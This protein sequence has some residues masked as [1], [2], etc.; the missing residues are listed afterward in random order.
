MGAGLEFNQYRAYNIGDDLR[1]LD[2]KLLARSDKYYLKQ[3]SI[4]RQNKVRFLLDTSASMQY[5]EDGISKFNY[6]RYLTA[7]LGYIAYLQGDQFGIHFCNGR[8]STSLLPQSS[9]THLH[10]FFHLLDEANAIGKWQIPQYES[11]YL[12]KQKNR[13][14]IIVISDWYEHKAEITKAST[15]ISC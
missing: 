1:L 4:E 12:S 13:E 5:E 14:L 15:T 2:W 7:A 9:S 6:A 3:S 10:H 11:L 8:T